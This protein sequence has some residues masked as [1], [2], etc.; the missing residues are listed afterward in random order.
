MANIQDEIN[1]LVN[2]IIGLQ[3]ADGSFIVAPFGRSDEYFSAYGAYALLPY[4]TDLTKK[5][6][7]YLIVG[8]VKKF[9]TTS[10]DS[11]GNYYIYNGASPTSSATSPERT[12]S[13]DAYAANLL[14]VVSRWYKLDKIARDAWLNTAITVGTSTVNYFSVLKNVCDYNI[15]NRI[16][17][18]GETVTAAGLV[19]TFQTDAWSSTYDKIAQYQD[20]LHCLAA[21]REFKKV[22]DGRGDTAFSSKLLTTFNTLITKVK[23]K[24]VVT[25]KVKTSDIAAAA[26]VFPNPSAPNAPRTPLYPDGINLIYSDIYGLGVF[27]NK[28]LFEQAYPNWD[29]DTTYD[30]TVFAGLPNGFLLTMVSR[31]FA[32]SKPTKILSQLATF[33]TLP[34]IKQTINE[35]AHMILALEIV[36]STSPV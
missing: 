29:T 22:S 4:R 35:L 3:Q 13:N 36:K 28:V 16:N 34:P 23:S 6:L 26:T 1:A 32:N 19:K 24:L 21:M 12:D 11:F 8:K 20:N 7:D 2:Q 15:I 25:Q 18:A 17:V 9:A 27:S 31:V 33:K 10:G 5:W 30:A 14:L